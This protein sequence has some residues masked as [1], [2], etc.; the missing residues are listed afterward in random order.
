[1]TPS[2][3]PRLQA[4]PALASDDLLA[5]VRHVDVDEIVA[6][7]ER[8]ARFAEGVRTLRVGGASI[9]LDERLLMVLGGILVPLG[10][11]VV[12]LGWWGAARS[13]YVF[14][15]LPYVISGG[16]LGV[17]LIFLGAFLYFA[18][19]MTEMVKES[20]RQSTAL[21]AAVERLEA[22]LAAAPT[23]K[24]ATNGALG[25]AVDGWVATQHGTMAHRPDC[26]V[27]A[28]KSGLR[29]VDPGRDDLPLCKLCAAS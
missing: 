14:D 15:Q 22:R 21:L 13:P 17:G 3:T 12:L 26:V 8:D 28:G 27:V 29:T 6:P 19:W 7:A 23:P 2:T 16:L 25:E 5:P 24:A 4:N 9:R 20:R 18:H 11:I 10:I 1:M